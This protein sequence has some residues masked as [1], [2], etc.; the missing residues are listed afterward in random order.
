MPIET[1]HLILDNN[2]VL[3][4]P[5]PGKVAV[6]VSD[7]ALVASTPTGAMPIAI[8]KVIAHP[9]TPTDKALAYAIDTG[10]VDQV[11]IKTEDGGVHRVTPGVALPVVVVVASQ[12][13]PA[14]AFYFVGAPGVTLTLDPG[15]A[16][17]QIMVASAVDDTVVVADGADL[18]VNDAG[19][20]VASFTLQQQVFYTYQF[21]GAPITQWLLMLR[22]S[23]NGYENQ[24]ALKHKI[25]GGGA[26]T[27]Y[28]GQFVNSTADGTITFP[29]V[30]GNWSGRFAVHKDYSGVGPTIAVA[31]GSLALP[32]GGSASSLDITTYPTGTT[33]EYQ[34]FSPTNRYEIVRLDYPNYGVYTPTLT[35]VA[36]VTGTTASQCHWSRVGDVVTVSGFFQVEPTIVTTLT[37]LNLSLPIASTVTSQYTLGGTGANGN[38]DEVVQIVGDSGAAE[39]LA[40]FISKSITSHEVS[41]SFS[42][43]ITT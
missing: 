18:I 39:A 7:G 6:G 13:A 16:R 5:G 35:G 22:N 17:D 34:A 42:Y 2:A 38:F 19:A 14:G 15:V 32:T 8:P 1:Q 23:T 41:F 33:I 27:A 30:S 40:R 36:N 31:A 4:T 3:P 26:L 20:G 43:Q 25:H 10:G 28:L 12:A 11:F 21:A 29:D 24:G 37:E 9:A